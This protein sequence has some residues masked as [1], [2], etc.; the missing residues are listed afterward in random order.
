MRWQ[1]SE[2]SGVL[3][4]AALRATVSERG[5]REDRVEDPDFIVFAALLELNYFMQRGR[6]AVGG[7]LGWGNQG[8]DTKHR[9]R[10]VRQRKAGLGRQEGACRQVAPLPCEQRAVPARLPR[11]WR[12]FGLRNARGGLR[13]V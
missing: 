9:G 13:R 10:R 12:A 7:P 11:C 6:G 3:W 2:V 1:L 8:M 5:Q 4:S